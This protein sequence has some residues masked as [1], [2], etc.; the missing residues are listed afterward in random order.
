MNHPW[1][2]ASAPAFSNSTDWEIWK[3]HWCDT[4]INDIDESCPIALDLLMY[5]ENDAIRQ[6]PGVRD[7]LFHICLEYEEKQS[8]G[9]RK[10][11]I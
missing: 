3:A 8:E 11:I 4:C 9:G 10:C 6:T 1:P 5:V 2:V 7:S